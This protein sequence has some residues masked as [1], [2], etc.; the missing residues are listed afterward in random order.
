M[1]KVGEQGGCTARTHPL[2][3]G[4][5]CTATAKFLP[6]MRICSHDPRFLPDVACVR[7]RKGVY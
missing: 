7:G 3:G 2:L 4:D 6:V 5:R 1:R